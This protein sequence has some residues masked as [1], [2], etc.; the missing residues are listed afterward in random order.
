M[1]IYYVNRNSNLKGPFDIIDSNRQHIIKVGDI[2]LRDTSDGIAFYVVYNSSNSWNSCKVVGFGDN[3]TLSDIGNTLLF[4]F[5]G[6]SR[7]KGNIA[8]IKQARMCFREKVIDDFFCNALD[9]LEYKRDFW[10]GSLFPQFFASSQELVD[11]DEQRKSDVS[12][13]TNHYPSIFAKYL[14]KE[15]LEQLINSLNEGNELKEAYQN[16]RKEHPELFRK[17]LMKFL[18]ENPG[19]TIFDKPA[20]A[21][22]PTEIVKEVEVPKASSHGLRPLVRPLVIS[23]NIEDEPFKTNERINKII[24]GLN[25][26]PFIS[27]E[28]E[29]ELAQKIRRGDGI[30]ARNKLVSA[31]LRFVVGIAKE[32]LHKGLEFEDLLHEGFL[33]L[34]K[35]AER[36]DETRGFKF[37]DY[38][39]WW[40]KR[41]LTDAIVRNSSLIHFPLSVRILH[42]RIWDFKVIY[43]HQN[44]YFPPVTDIEIAGED[45]LDRISFLNSLPNNLSNACI[46]CEDYDVFEEY[47]NDILDYE[48]NEYK[49]YYVRSLLARLSKRERDILIRVFG[50]GVREE[51]LE[52]IGE[53]RG[54]TRERVRQIREK[55]IKKLREMVIV[56]SAEGQ[57]SKSQSTQNENGSSHAITTKTTE[58]T[59]TLR[60]V[61]K[62]FSQARFNIVQLTEAKRRK[63]AENDKVKLP[64]EKTNET[65]RKVVDLNTRN[66]SVVNY[67]GKCNIYDH[68]RRLVY[69][70]TGS[71][72]EINQSYYRV[73][74]TH[75]FF[76]IG[77]IK[78]NIKGD[79]FNADKIL[80]ANQQ[81]KLHHKLKRK[82]FIEMIEDIK[83]DGRRRLKVDGCWYD[84]RGNVVFENTNSD[85]NIIELKKVEKESIE[86]NN[87]P[88]KREIPNVID[89]FGVEHVF[90]DTS[91]ALPYR[92]VE[93]EIE[94]PDKGKATEEGETLPIWAFAENIRFAK[95]SKQFLKCKCCVGLSKTGYYLIV[96]HRYIKLGDY[97]N[98]YE[99]N[100]GNIWIKR[101]IDDKGYRMV[102]ENGR[103]SYLIGYAKEKGRNVVFTNPANDVYSVSFDGRITSGI[104]NKKTISLNEIDNDKLRHAFD[105]KA[106]SYKY[107]W[108]LAILKIYNE[109]RM[110]SILFKDI[111]IEMVSIAWRY[112]FVV[113]CQFP[114]QD[115]LPIYL[116]AI[117]AKTYLDR[118]AKEKKVEETVRESFY[119]WKWNTLLMPLLNNVPYRFLS[120]WIPFTNN[121]DV[122]SKS[123]NMEIGCPYGLQ[124]DHITINPIWGDYFVENYDK[125]IL[126]VEKEL[127]SYLKCE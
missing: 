124:N 41:Y 18:T 126:F 47:H 36:F 109:T 66:Y 9:I 76:S 35:A 79:L 12:T 95:R 29:I 27:I 42:R 3:D 96:N 46:P 93:V 121:D 10:E 53:S 38:A 15:L 101:P 23:E 71:V 51:T 77:L 60:E 48:D 43:E 85:S 52:M 81:T 98:G 22:V 32:Y 21:Y 78:R 24:I 61:K 44:G 5:D 65:L 107:F 28:E 80:L 31:N 1:N 73:S 83:R 102:H 55:A 64:S 119:E 4:S 54:L 62:A 118:Y 114:S 111:L 90:V 108:F 45:D 2:C 86:E 56:T 26:Q 8:L 91:D 17:A 34:I 82:D 103:K 33:G 68:N 113:E 116:R 117:Q 94:Q 106:T 37:I 11:R 74:L 7:R 25:R 14:N 58:E 30:N 122:K 57:L 39:V 112:V 120:P 63:L 92:D 84:E 97:P 89:E 20:D 123:R 88:I 87:T 67:N 75:T 69:S 115:Q 50:I 105:K 70:S 127:R 99:C 16:L 49:K 72:I 125:I 110:D 6:L 104:K 13:D 19:G 59:Q 100:V 40:I